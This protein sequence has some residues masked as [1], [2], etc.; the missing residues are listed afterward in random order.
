MSIYIFVLYPALELDPMPEIVTVKAMVSEASQ[1]EIEKP[2]GILRRL[3]SAIDGTLR[4]SFFR[5]GHFVASHPAATIMLSTSFVFLCATGAM[6]FHT[7]DRIEVL[8]A[9]PN[10]DSV[11]H[12]GILYEYFEKRST[13]SLIVSSNIEREEDIANVSSLIQLIE[14]LEVVEQAKAVQN[15]G[16]EVSLGS[17]CVTSRQGN[18]EFCS[19]TSVLVSCIFPG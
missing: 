13:A 16:E 1:N 10:S 12:E 17:I 4:S 6:M 15:D 18:T 11:R 19:M 14:L 5:L 9:P 8:L 2:G 7:E 3:S